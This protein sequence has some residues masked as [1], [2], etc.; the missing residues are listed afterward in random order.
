VT[1]TS[2]ISSQVHT[3]KSIACGLP[4]NGKTARKIGAEMAITGRIG[5]KLDAESSI[6]DIF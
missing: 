3:A 6:F 1:N 4:T 2:S 5:K